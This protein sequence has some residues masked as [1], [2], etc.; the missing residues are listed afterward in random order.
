MFRAVSRR[1]V[2]LFTPRRVEQELD[3]ELAAHLA[4][5][6]A[7]HIA[8]GMTPAD[9]AAA[10][11]R[12]FGNL[13]QVREDARDSWRIAALDN[14]QRHLR[15]A[16]RALMRRPAFTA[17]ALLSIALGL[18]SAITV[19]SVI[20]ATLLRPLPYP[21]PEQLVAIG[22][23]QFLAN[24][25][26]AALRQQAQSY[27][28]IGSFSPG[29][30]FPLTGPTPALLVN[31][32]KVSGNFFEIMG[33]RP[34]LGAGFGMSAETPGNHRVAVLGEDLWNR[35]YHRDPAIVGQ[36]ITLDSRPYLVTGIMPRAF[37]PIDAGA[38]LWIPMAMDPSD[39][40]WASAITLVVARLRPG[41]SVATA[42]AEMRMI[43][44][45]MEKEFQHTA[46]WA[47]GVT[48]QGAEERALGSVRPVLIVLSMAVV[49]LL[50]TAT[51][52]VANLLLVRTTER[53]QELAV[54]SS[55]GATARQLG[56]LVLTE[57][58]LLGI[59]GGVLGLVGAFAAVRT[60]PHILPAGFPRVAEIAISG[61]VLVGAAI[62][63]MLVCALFAIAPS[64]LGTAENVGIRLR[65]GRT[66][67]GGGART[68]GLFLATEVA[69]AVVL[70]AG[71]ALM[72]RTMFAL[73]QVDRGIRSDHVLTMRVMP[74]GKTA[75]A[76][77]VYWT[78]VL[79]RVRHLPGV[80]SAATVLHLP[81]GGRKWSANVLVD[82]RPVAPGAAP[83]R[84]AWQSV[85]PDYFATVGIPVVAGRP[86][87]TADDANA[88]K[89]IAV[90]GV[91][92][93]KIFPGENP[94]GKRV[95]AGNATGG[96]T[97]TIVAVVG[98][99]RHDSLNVPAGAEL[100]VPYAQNPVGATGVVI[101]TTGE[102]A[103]M[104]GVLRDQVQ[105]VDPAAPI[106]DVR[107]M[108]EV[109][110]RSMQRPRMVL[111]LMGVFA[112]IALL[113]SAIG[114]YGVVAYGVRQRLREIGIRVAL[115]ADH[116]SIRRLVVGQGLGYAILGVTV[117]LP[118][119]LAL[120]RFMR[121]LVFGIATSDALSFVVVPVVL[122]LIA[123]IASML[124]TRIAV[125]GN[126]TDVLRE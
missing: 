37:H 40:P 69:L 105:A 15:F 7:R 60:L 61:R 39:Q 87:T 51:A 80:R 88:P 89:V 99:V 102:P 90:N 36:S 101:R 116:W 110:A 113:L 3:G 20:D 47:T 73:G 112:S 97:A 57:C 122:L 119:A 4:E 42:S 126:P 63:T 10:A 58:L 111:V 106:T 30:L 77:R 48:I 81:M 76:R 55:L 124:P 13:G 118:I 32:G 71:A 9:A 12:E 34:I 14:L 78:E 85:S 50:L 41:A 91:F 70:L 117:G 25:E 68:R 17:T 31:A 83:A 120:T 26:V 22:N 35:A 79:E 96:D 108:D 52:N 65:S 19:Y 95:S 18:A 100:Y 6:T 21:A 38:D 107:A 123:G 114:V 82:G 103:A 29:W 66:I 46:G 92:A 11:R 5:E 104:A 2:A 27:T 23:D 64:L 93:A 28:N 43:A 8:R 74:G 84:S 115:G 54:R 67:A 75:D 125:R 49:L 33:V 98:N 45:R 1:V 24:R 44:P 121:G 109:Y 56:A 53:R 59:I 94:I 86:F 16:S 62:L 72:G